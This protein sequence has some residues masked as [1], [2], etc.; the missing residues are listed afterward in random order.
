MT[1]SHF[2]WNNRFLLRYET[3]FTGNRSLS[4]LV[5]LCCRSGSTICSRRVVPMR[6]IWIITYIVGR[7][8]RSRCV[9][10][11]LTDHTLSEDVNSGIWGGCGLRR[12]GGD[13]DKTTQLSHYWLHGEKHLGVLNGWESHLS[14]HREVHIPRDIHSYRLRRAP[15]TEVTWVSI[16]R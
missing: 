7:P 9:S 11:Q 12:G 3:F 14:G 10:G 13:I 6:M 4:S 1:G 16:Q 8:G 15:D 2:L 5:V